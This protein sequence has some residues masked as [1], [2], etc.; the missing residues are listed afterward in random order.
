MEQHPLFIKYTRDWLHQSTGFSKH[1]LCKIATR[2]TPLT[3]SFIERVCH[4]LNQPEGELF[5]PG[6]CLQPGDCAAS[7]IGQW[8]E[9]KCKA[10][11]L[12]FRQ[13]ATKTGVSH[14]TIAG[15]IN[16][17]SPSIET[18]KK[19]ARSFSGN[20]TLRLALEDHLFA[21][22]GYRERPEELS[23]QNYLGIIPLLSP[24]HQHI[25]EVL[26]RELAKI[27]GIEMR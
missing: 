14:Q 10:E 16:G 12:S 17:T 19:L 27:E 22:A 20:G 21:L 25:L 4:K 24:Q 2:R 6:E 3:R 18:I 5:L 23:G 7:A 11:H 26:V 9:E 1:Y 13:V 15:I 8:L